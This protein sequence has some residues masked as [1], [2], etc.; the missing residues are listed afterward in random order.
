[1]HIMEGQI[2]TWKFY[3]NAV[4]RRAYLCRESRGK[5]GGELCLQL[6]FD[7]FKMEKDEGNVAN[8]IGCI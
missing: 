6:T 7:F 8:C 5:D 3:G 1:M 2:H 4:H